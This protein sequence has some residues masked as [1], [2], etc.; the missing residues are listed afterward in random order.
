MRDTG[1]VFIRNHEGD[2]AGCDWRFNGWGEKENPHDAD[3]A[4]A[5]TLLLHLGLQ[6]FAAPCVLE[7]GAV[8]VDGAGTLLTTD[9][10][11]L[12][13]NRNL[14]MDRKTMERLLRDYLGVETVIWLAGGLTGDMTDGHVDNVACFVRPGV[15]LAQTCEDPANPNHA[16]LRENRR[17]LDSAR[18][19]QGRALTVLPLPQPE[20]G[21]GGPSA[22]SYVN[23]YIANGGIVMPAFGCP[24][25]SE[26]FAII[27]RAFP[28]REVVQIDARAI[29][30][31]GGGIHCITQQQSIS[32]TTL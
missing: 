25:D 18:D 1:P 4:V 19:A 9:S 31:G 14:G 12:N 27:A 6:R 11:L 15:V 21:S 16:M 20:A 17:I 32:G 8:H 5:E 7:G 26:A 28:E 3:V 10:V 2:V 22:L 13:P 24:Q 23:F 30:A 29:L